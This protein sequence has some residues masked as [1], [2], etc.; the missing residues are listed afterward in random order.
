MPLLASGRCIQR[1]P[2]L[3]F[4]F[5]QSASKT[6]E[7]RVSQVRSIMNSS[8]LI[9]IICLLITFYA[10]GSSVFFT[11]SFT[12]NVLRFQYSLFDTFPNNRNG[13]CNRD[14]S[15]KKAPLKPTIRS[16][17]KELW[18]VEEESQTILLTAQIFYLKL[19]HLPWFELGLVTIS[20]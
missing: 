14:N 4:Q 13:Q 8:I 10:L 18:N 12:S 17:R 20:R 6:F 1:S 16:E 3:I 5:C 11:L 19:F 2:C 15:I 9:A 7:T